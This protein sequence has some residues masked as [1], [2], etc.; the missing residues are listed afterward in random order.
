MSTDNNTNEEIDINYIKNIIPEDIDPLE[1][2][3]ILFEYK[4]IIKL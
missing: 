2:L 1:G 3:F 4:K